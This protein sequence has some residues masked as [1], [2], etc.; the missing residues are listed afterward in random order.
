[1]AMT[2]S[3]EYPLFK[4]NSTPFCD[5]R[6][7]SIR[8]FCQFL[9][10][11]L[12]ALALLI[13]SLVCQI[14]S[15]NLACVYFSMASIQFNRGANALSSYYK[16]GE[17]LI[18][19]SYN[20]CIIASPS[21]TEQNALRARYGSNEIDQWLQIGTEE[22]PLRLE[23]LKRK[24]GGLCLGMTLDF[25]KQYLQQ[26]QHALSPMEAI[27]EISSLYITGASDKA[28]L[29]QIFYFALDSTH[30]IEKECAQLSAFMENQ[31]ADA[32]RCL[33]EQQKQIFAIKPS[34]LTFG[35]QTNQI[36]EKLTQLKT[37]YNERLNKLQSDAISRRLLAM[38]RIEAQCNEIL[39]N[40]LGLQ[41]SPAR[42]YAHEGISA[43]YDV[44]FSQFLEDLPND[45]YAGVFRSKGC[46]HA[47][48]LIK[49]SDNQYF[50][51]EPNVGTLALRKDESAEKLWNIGK[52]YLKN[53]LCSI[54]FSS[55]RLK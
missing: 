54:S 25:I 33:D 43:K 35:N 4:I 23:K 5:T 42:I 47:V 30:A 2:I 49:A 1:M 3:A 7:K 55:C 48:A 40:Q 15:K 8:V 11:S 39:A 13:A 20:G 38:A 14:F 19:F 12:Y 41:V 6:C 27:R 36:L 24:E 29:A 50:L 18:D 16:F 44:D 46:A 52:S 32:L 37:Q 22:T 53:G 28:Q 9:G 10:R 17:A 21:D 45:C 31:Q 51:F 26:I 34:A